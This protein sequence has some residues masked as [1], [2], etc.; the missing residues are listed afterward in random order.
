MMTE[1]RLTIEKQKMLVKAKMIQPADEAIMSKKD[2]FTLAGD[3]IKNAKRKE[4]Y[5]KTPDIYI[6][7]NHFDY[8][9]VYYSDFGD[10]TI[11]TGGY[12]ITQRLP[13][14]NLTLEFRY[15]SGLSNNI[16]IRIY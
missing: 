4:I 6:G 1:K 13:N 10:F 2:F 7:Y 9:K 14:S 3:I 15:S 8:L 5:G 12:T 16:I 11:S